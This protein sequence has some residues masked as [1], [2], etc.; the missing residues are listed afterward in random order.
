[1]L[2]GI[3]FDFDGVI[4]E[5]VKVKTEAFA[6]LYSPYGKGIVK[7][8][9]EHHKANGGISRFEKFKLYHKLFLNT[10]LTSSDIDQMSNKFSFLV[11]S[12][13][14]SCPYV[15]GVMDF[16]KKTS[17]KYKLFI[18]TGTPTEEIKTILKGRGIEN[19]FTNVY[20]SPQRKDNHIK[21][22]MKNYNFN[23]KQLLFFGDSDSDL[24]AAKSMEVKFILR[25]HSLN[26][27]YYPQYNGKTIEDFFNL[28][29]E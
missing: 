19:Y 8:V 26:K 16:I 12:K 21:Q 28:E 22:I 4:A 6:E 29:I 3:I 17:E 23:H 15:P 5:S 27:K 14:I 20:G 7:K 24:N 13:V 9:V 2:K 1:M 18:S 25:L 10:D 11:V